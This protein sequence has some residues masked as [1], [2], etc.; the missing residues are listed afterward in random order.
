[1]KEEIDLLEY[2]RK[3]YEE[4]YNLICGTDEA[5]RGPL[6]GPVVA[7]AVIMPKNYHLDGLNDSKKLTEKKR[8]ELFPII[9]RDAI[10]YGIAVI[11]AKTIDK[12]NILEASRL[13]MTQ[14]ITSM[15]V[16]P[17]YILSDAMKLN[18]DIPVLPIIHGDAKSVNIAAASILAKVTRD[19][20]MYEMDKK[21]PY[22]E[23]AKH[24][25]YPT[26]R[27]LELLKIYGPNEEYRFT[28]RPIHDLINKGD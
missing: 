27:H 10:S 22:L 7:A 24:K 19:H 18:F 17:E 25:G 3:L 20:I 26:K 23:L 6:V 1:M 28:Y 12:I 16:K 14:A 13:G 15:S 4:G 5:G 2:E 9:K 11:D 8:E 21:Y